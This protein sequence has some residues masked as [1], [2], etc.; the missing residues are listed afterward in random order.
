MNGEIISLD[1]AKEL[2]HL[3]I[4]NSNLEKRNEELRQAIEE[5]YNY[6]EDNCIIEDDDGTIHLEVKAANMIYIRGRLRK[7]L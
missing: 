5:T 2:T 6:I 1:T 3:R 7:A 4:A